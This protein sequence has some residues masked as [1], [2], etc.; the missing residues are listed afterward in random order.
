MKLLKV[1]ETKETIK[2]REKLFIVSELE[3]VLKIGFVDG[4]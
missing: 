3:L 4:F 1:R 2:A